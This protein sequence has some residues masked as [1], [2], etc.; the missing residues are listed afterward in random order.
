MKHKKIV[1]KRSHGNV[2]DVTLEKGIDGA[3]LATVEGVDTV[4]ESV[5]NRNNQY[6]VKVS[7]LYDEQDVIDEIVKTVEEL[8]TPV[9]HRCPV[10]G[11]PNAVDEELA[12]ECK[13]LVNESM[14]ILG[15]RDE[16]KNEYYS[17]LN[18]LRDT[19]STISNLTRELNDAKNALGAIYS[20]SEAWT[21]GYDE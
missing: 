3:I 19:Q 7:P 1:V 21:R 5:L 11:G 10:C 4:S 18:R 20:L 9:T 13:R 8:G 6:T 15:E 12:K 14:K 16:W 17:T 2:Y